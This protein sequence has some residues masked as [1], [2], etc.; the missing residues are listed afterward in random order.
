MQGSAPA[1]SQNPAPSQSA[2]CAHPREAAALVQDVQDAQ[3]LALDQV[4]HVLV[5]HEGDVGPVDGLALVLRLLH[6]EH[7][8][9]EV[10]LQLLIGQVD[11]KLLKV[12]LLEALEA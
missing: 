4:Q 12:I 2:L 7:V 1:T 5:V 9:V 8:L 11:A 6:L 3:G 10:L